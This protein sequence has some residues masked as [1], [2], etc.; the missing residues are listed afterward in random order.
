MKNICILICKYKSMTLFTSIPLEDI[1]KLLQD[2]NQ[3]IS[4]DR[5]KRYVDS[6]NYIV[7]HSN[8]NLPHPI[9]DWFL[10]YDLSQKKIVV[11]TYN[12]SSIILRQ[13]NLSSLAKQ[14]VVS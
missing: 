11:G 4:Q 8:I 12:A 1:T 14:F 10:A 6:Y 2:N 5:Q 3:P 7:S 13:I 9:R